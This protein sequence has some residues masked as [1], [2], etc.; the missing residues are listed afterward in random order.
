MKRVLVALVAV[1]SMGAVAC[2]N[3]DCEDAADKIVDECG[4][5]D[6]GLEED[7]VAECDADAECVAQCTN[8]ASCS[9]PT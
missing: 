9:E 1:V 5:S 4:I 3:N 6:D 7:E 8:D 2:G